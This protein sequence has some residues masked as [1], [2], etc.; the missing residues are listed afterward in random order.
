MSGTRVNEIYV[1]MS[2]LGSFPDDGPDPKAVVKQTA[3]MKAGGKKAVLRSTAHCV[4]YIIHVTGAVNRD[5]N[6]CKTI[7]ENIE[8]GV[9]EKSKMCSTRCTQQAITTVST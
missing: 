3:Q 5:R 7:C 1:E 4:L 2:K 8:Q 9:I 6:H